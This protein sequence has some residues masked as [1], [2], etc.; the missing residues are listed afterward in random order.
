MLTALGDQFDK[1]AERR[2]HGRRHEE[3]ARQFLRN[4]DYDFD[5]CLH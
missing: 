1:Y 4:G 5:A 2:S 3:I